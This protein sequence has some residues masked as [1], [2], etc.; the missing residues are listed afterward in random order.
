M[1]VCIFYKLLLLFG[2]I[3]ISLYFLNEPLEILRLSV[4]SKCKL[5]SLMREADTFLK[6]YW[7]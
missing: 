1:R 4:L 6:I 2:V 5:S 7:V 3:H